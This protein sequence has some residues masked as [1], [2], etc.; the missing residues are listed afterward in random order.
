MAPENEQPARNE[1][2]PEETKISIQEFLETVPP[3]VRREISGFASPI[4]GRITGPAP[5]WQFE[6]VAINL[7][8]DDSACERVQF[9]ENTDQQTIEL[10]G[11]ALIQPDLFLH[12]R[13]R[14][15]RRVGK[16][17]AVRVISRQDRDGIVIKIGESPPFGSPL[18]ARLQRLVQTERDL[19]I[20]GFRSENSGFGIGA[21][22]YYRRIVE[23]Q[24]NS[25]ID[26]IIKACGKI[27]G[28]DKL[29][30][31]LERARGERQFSKA[32]EN[33][34]DAVPDALKIDGRNPM[35]LLH[36][37]LSRRIHADTDEACLDAA[38][39]IRTILV[40]FL[41]L[42]ALINKDDSEVTEAIRRLTRGSPP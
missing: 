30:P 42:L 7:F 3:G 5:K 37:A 16:T 19:L 38:H 27:A 33:I 9:F 21:F 41:E 15:C 22:A 28:A 29:I 36:Q 40:K 2:P 1:C 4:P 31:D 17:F 25:L 39:A 18:P 32:V 11:I 13:C 24:K 35:T 34:A 8:C 10:P 12:Y 14:N 23:D 6:R 26:Q 20:K